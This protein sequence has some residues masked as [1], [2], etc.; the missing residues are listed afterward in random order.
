MVPKIQLAVLLTMT[1]SPM[2]TMISAMTGRLWNG[3]ITSRSIATP[4]AKA[5][6]MVRKNAP[7]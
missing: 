6:T 2:N 1:N 7:Q 3:R 5:K 4:A